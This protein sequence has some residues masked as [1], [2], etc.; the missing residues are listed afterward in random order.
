MFEYE[1]R[2]TFYGFDR[3][4]TLCAKPWWL[5]QDEADV[6][7]ITKTAY[8]MLRRG[9]CTEV[10]VVDSC[11]QLASA[12]KDLKRIVE[13]GGDKRIFEANMEFWDYVKSFEH[14][15]FK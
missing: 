13:K 4:H 10:I 12:Y 6:K 11:H 5:R 14:L 9:D 2:I 1:K 3:Y 7:A 8:D 15:E